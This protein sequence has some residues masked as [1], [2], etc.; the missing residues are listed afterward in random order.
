MNKPLDEESGEEVKKI[1]IRFMP[2]NVLNHFA[3]YAIVQHDGD[4]NVFTLTFYDVQKPPLMGAKEE[5]DA[6]LKQL[7][8]EGIPAVCL[9]RIVMNPPHFRRFVATLQKHLE[10]LDSRQAEEKPISDK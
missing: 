10:R 7:E 6:G 2:T 9:A 1:P 8:E 3:N 4:H 5:I